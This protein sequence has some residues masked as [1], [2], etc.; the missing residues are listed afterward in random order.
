MSEISLYPSFTSHDHLQSNQTH[1]FTSSS[2]TSWRGT[3]WGMSKG[4]LDLLNHL[5]SAQNPPVY[6]WCLVLQVPTATSSDRLPPSPQTFVTISRR[7]QRTKALCAL[8]S[9]R[10]A[11]VCLLDA[12]QMWHETSAAQDPRCVQGRGLRGGGG[13]DVGKQVYRG[14]A[15]GGLRG[16]CVPCSER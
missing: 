3:W 1:A 4:P 9:D 13:R 2:F 8:R 14:G 12:R 16:A 5:Q 7:E 6:C 15:G 11:V 10:F